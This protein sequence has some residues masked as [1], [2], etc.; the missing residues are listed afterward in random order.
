MTPLNQSDVCIW[1]CNTS[2]L[3][4]GVLQSAD[5]HL[6]VEERTRRDR[7]HFGVDRRDFTIAHDLLRRTLSRYTNIPPANWRFSTN[8]F[9]KPSIESGDPQVRTLSFNLS[10]VRG[11]AACALTPSAPLG[12]DIECID[13]SLCIEEI[14]SRYFSKE[15]A[16]WL[17]RCSDNSRHARFAE[18]W[19]LKESFLKAT[20]LGLS[21][22]LASVSFR[23][24]EHTAIE[25]SAP[26]TIDPT[27]WH[28]ALF[29]P[30]DY[31]RLAIAVHSTTRPRFFAR[32][33]GDEKRGFAPIRWSVASQTWLKP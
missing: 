9:G 11:W 33:E 8:D 18:L 13:Q 15:E 10:Y 31:V 14:A 32:R 17:R 12:I 3:D 1:F 4:D 19:T 21:G 20:G 29:K 26:S 16:I 23:F 22:S 28:F 2:C 7:L 27:E 25:F 6:S 30:A 24:D 5:Q